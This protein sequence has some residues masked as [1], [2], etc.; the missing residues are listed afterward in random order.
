[1]SYSDSKNMTLTRRTW[2]LRE[3]DF[4]V[5]VEGNVDVLLRATL[6]LATPAGVTI[7]GGYGFLGFYNPNF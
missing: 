5:D 7:L 6:I 3:I 1:M 2:E 4:C